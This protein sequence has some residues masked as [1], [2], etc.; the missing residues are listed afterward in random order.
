MWS[1]KQGCSLH[2]LLARPQPWLLRYAQAFA[3][4]QPL[5][6]AS[7]NFAIKGGSSQFSSLRPGLME[8]AHV[9]A[10]PSDD[11]ILLPPAG[12]CSSAAA[13]ISALSPAARRTAAG[14]AA[15]RNERHGCTHARAT[16]VRS[17]ESR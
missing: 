14:T 12:R 8:T 2:R 9:P 6:I 17:T 15:I 11:A 1:N 4:P 16:P 3:L 7:D 13:V 5:P 10:S